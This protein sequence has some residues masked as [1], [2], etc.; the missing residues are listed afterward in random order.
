MA[1]IRQY[2]G[3]RYVIKIYENSQDPSSAEWE[4]GNFEP[5]VMVT[6]QNGSYLSKKEVPASVGNPA[7]NPNYWVQT[8]FYNG[9]I[10]SLQAQIDA[11]NNNELPTITSAIQTLTDDVEAIKD[12]IDIIP[13]L[14]DR[15]FIILTD[16]YGYEPAFTFDLFTELIPQNLGISSGN[17][18]TIEAN[19][20][21]FINP[22]STLDGYQGTFLQQLQYHITSDY[23]TYTDILVCAGYNDGHNYTQA[24]IESAIQSFVTYCKTTFTNAKVHIGHIGWDTDIDNQPIMRK[25]IAAYRNCYKYGATYIKNAEY[26]C[27]DYDHFYDAIHPDATAQNRLADYLGQYILYGKFDVEYI[28]EFTIDT[29]GSGV[30]ADSDYAPI[31]YTKLKNDAVTLMVGSK[32]QTAMLNSAKFIVDN[33]TLT[34]GGSVNLFGNIGGLAHPFYLNVNEHLDQANINCMAFNSNGNIQ[35]VPLTILG[36]TGRMWLP[37]AINGMTAIHVAPVAY[38]Y[39]TL[40]C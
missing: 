20:G 36:V 23:D 9:Q 13:D 7:N 17:W 10:A 1:N 18:T 2:I 40:W 34:A 38:H 22:G 31:I 25:S 11:I 6:W 3:A 12:T 28:S 30:S 26:I 8:G 21:G 16:S 27:H 33:V 35:Y 14:A 5:L 29:F 4:Q 19:G 32:N 39:E 15:K 24:Q 37:Q